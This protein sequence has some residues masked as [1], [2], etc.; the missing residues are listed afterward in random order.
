M[1]PNQQL[2]VLLLIGAIAYYYL[3]NENEETSTGKTGDNQNDDENDGTKLNEIKGYKEFNTSLA[4]S[5]ALPAASLQECYD[6]AV[7]NDALAY[8][9]RNEKHIEEPLKNTCALLSH[10]GTGA[11]KG[12]DA[13]LSGCA[14]ITKSLETNCE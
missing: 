7:E 9:Y 12:T 10:A 2:I 11:I 14:D 3:E 8:I 6:L 5:G 13:H 4:D 1:D